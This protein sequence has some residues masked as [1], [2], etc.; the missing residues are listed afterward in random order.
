MNAIFVELWKKKCLNISGTLRPR[1]LSSRYIRRVGH[2]EHWLPDQKLWAA[3]SCPTD[4][5]VFD[6][7]TLDL[8]DSDNDLSI[9]HNEVVA[10][11]EW[12]CRFLKDKSK[13][14]ESS[15]RLSFRI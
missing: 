1:I 2:R 8:I 15:F 5:L 4:G 14:L 7:K 3:L 11:V 6:S 12:V 10:A 9:R 13:L